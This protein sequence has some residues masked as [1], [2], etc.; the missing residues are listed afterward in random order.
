MNQ[1]TNLARYNLTDQ[2]LMEWKLTGQELKWHQ[3]VRVERKFCSNV[4]GE[5]KNKLHESQTE[6]TNVTI[7]TK[8][9]FFKNSKISW[10]WSKCGNIHQVAIH[11]QAWIILTENF[12]IFYRSAFPRNKEEECLSFLELDNRFIFLAPLG[13]NCVCK[14]G[15]ASC[16]NSRYIQFQIRNRNELARSLW[17]DFAQ[18]AVRAGDDKKFIGLVSVL[19]KHRRL[20]TMKL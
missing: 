13:L 6:L 14:S 17:N 11:G 7:W 5:S 19:I 2:Q 12:R 15:R 20:R 8:Q 10:F 1:G 3:H 9:L 16:I 18:R 4:I